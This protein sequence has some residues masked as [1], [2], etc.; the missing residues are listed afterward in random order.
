MKDFIFSQKKMAEQSRRLKS[1]EN[2]SVA[3][4]GVSRT[5]AEIPQKDDAHPKRASLNVGSR[6]R[7]VPPVQQSRRRVPLSNLT[8]QPPTQSKHGIPHSQGFVT[9]PTSSKARARGAP[10]GTRDS[11]IQKGAAKSSIPRHPAKPSNVDL[12]VPRNNVAHSSSVSSNPDNSTLSPAEK[13]S[14]TTAYDSAISTASITTEALATD[15]SASDIASLEKKTLQNLYISKHHSKPLEVHLFEERT[16]VAAGVQGSKSVDI[17]A[18]NRDPQ[19]CAFYASDIYDHLHKMEKKR[20]PSTD[21]MEVVQQDIST[22][23][24]GILIDW[25][26]EVAEE[27]KLVPET[28][29]LTVSY[30]DRYLSRNV[31]VR[32]RLQLVGISC[33]LIASKHEEISPPQVEEFCYITD[34]T[35]FRDEVVAMERQVLCQLH[36]EL[37]DATIK[38][39]LGR[40]IRAAQVCIK[41]LQ[42]EFLANYL[43]ELTLLEYSFLKYL[44]S[45]IAASVVFLAK[46]TLNPTTR[47]WNATLKHYTCYP[48]SE[49]RECVKELHE[50]QCN[51]KNCTLTAIRDKY[52][53]HKFKCVST[54]VPP[55]VIPSDLFFDIDV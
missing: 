9:Q 49:L 46:F 27:Y 19:M 53:Q 43:A 8:N 54:L 41:S 3:A 6:S 12:R 32:Q 47:P 25:L 11:E 16:P 45:L 51:T 20:R 26:V 40:F 38:S 28:L 52:R 24:R 31:T 30:I 17:D 4:A 55:A 13:I 14:T 1:R 2:P 10:S 21:Y 42:L 37:S 15:S 48:A 5:T 34:N 18:D 23:M 50:L 29:F 22:S 35:Y 36:F 44:P 33:M 7:A 39:F